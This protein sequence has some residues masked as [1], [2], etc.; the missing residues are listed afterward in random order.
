MA[1]RVAAS[2][3]VGAWFAA[4][5]VPINTAYAILALAPAP[6]TETCIS[7]RRRLYVRVAV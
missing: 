5:Q 6:A 4:A 3:V 2:L 1:L 7:E